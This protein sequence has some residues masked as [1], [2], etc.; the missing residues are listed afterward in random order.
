MAMNPFT[1]SVYINDQFNRRNNG[2][3]L[4]LND[5]KLLCSTSGN[6][7]GEASNSKVATPSTTFPKPVATIS[8]PD[9]ALAT[10]K[11][12]PASTIS[13]PVSDSMLLQDLMPHLFSFDENPDLLIRNINIVST[14]SSLGS[15]YSNVVPQI[16]SHYL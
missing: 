7:N 12:Q 8:Q 15:A 6:N 13:I 9:H 4:S 5:N 2:L 16:L 11:P 14:C 3:R 1:S 10:E